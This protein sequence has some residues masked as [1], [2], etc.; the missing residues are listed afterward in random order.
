MDQQQIIDRVSGAENALA[1]S[2]VEDLE[3]RIALRRTRIRQTQERLRK[4]AMPGN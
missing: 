4:F 3:T 2:R 1:D